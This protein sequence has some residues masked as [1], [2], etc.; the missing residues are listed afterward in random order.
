MM[1]ANPEITLLTS[2]HC[3]DCNLLKR[4]LTE[5]EIPFL[6]QQF[7]DTTGS[8]QSGPLTILK[9]RIISGSVSD[10]KSAIFDALTVSVLG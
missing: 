4:W 10:Q 6:E 7:F 8:Y 1:H 3:P 9:D 2:P 5:M